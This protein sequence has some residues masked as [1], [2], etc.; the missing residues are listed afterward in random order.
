VPGDD[1]V[2]ICGGTDAFGQQLGHLSQVSGS[3][4]ST[5]HP[6]VHAKSILRIQL[7]L[8]KT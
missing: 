2:T 7:L 5:R 6:T 3:R 4:P 8:D 1:G